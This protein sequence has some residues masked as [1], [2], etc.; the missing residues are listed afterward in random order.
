MTRLVHMEGGFAATRLGRFIDDHGYLS[1]EHLRDEAA[2]D[3]A[4]FWEEMSVAVGLQWARR[5]DQVLDLSDGKPWPEWFVG[6]QLDLYDNLVGR[7][8]RRQ[9]DKAAL[10]CEDGDGRVTVL[11]YAQLD[12]QARRLAAGVSR[13]GIGA[14]RCAPRR[15]CCC[16]PRCASAPSSC[17]CSP[18]T[19]SMR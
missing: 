16:W 18:A 3:P 19:A 7:H 15:R 10:R 8:A 14:C 11:S 1:L 6:G 4:M 5:P 12:D 17:R 13:L 9:P 2:A